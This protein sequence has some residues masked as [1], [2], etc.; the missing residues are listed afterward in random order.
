MGF[1]VIKKKKKV[2]DFRGNGFVFCLFKVM[3]L[4]NQKK[5]KKKL[6][7]WVEE[8]RNSPFVFFFGYEIVCFFVELTLSYMLD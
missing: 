6:C 1:G 8:G 3:Y 5:K 4:V 2:L 7:T